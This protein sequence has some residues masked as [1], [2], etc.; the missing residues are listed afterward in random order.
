MYFLYEYGLCSCVL[1]D[2]IQRNAA[3]PDVK[4]KQISVI[5]ALGMQTMDCMETHL[6]ALYLAQ[7]QENR[8]WSHHSLH[9]KLFPQ[10]NKKHILFVFFSFSGP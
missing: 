7:L 10:W 9:G 4:N 5:V 6:T 1:Y 3:P 8:T 2:V